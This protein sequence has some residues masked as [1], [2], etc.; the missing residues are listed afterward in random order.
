MYSQCIGGAGRS[1]KELGSINIVWVL[2]AGPVDLETILPQTQV[3]RVGL[4]SL[5]LLKKLI[6]SAPWYSHG[7]S[8]W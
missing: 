6:L 2:Q 3:K 7:N 4:V 1:Q 5:L 8:A